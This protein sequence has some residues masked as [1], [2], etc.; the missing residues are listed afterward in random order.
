MNHARR[1]FQDALVEL[2]P[3]SA[4]LGVT[5]AV[6][7]LHPNCCAEFTFLKGID[8]V[9]SLLE[10]VGSPQVKM[11]FD[12][13]HV[14]FGSRVVERI[15]QWID[16]IAL[17][18]L[19]DG[20]KPPVAEQ[21]RCRLREGVIPLKEIVA[22]LAACGYQ[23]DYDVELLGEEVETLEYGELLEHAKQAFASLVGGR[24]D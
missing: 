10:A 23:G 11:V 18:Q 20:R 22:A 9:V 21:N 15:P 19:G 6:E 3:E 7:P 24:T 13:Y 14:G 8:D 12:T 5:L 2:A 4:E 1:L 17:V 16:H